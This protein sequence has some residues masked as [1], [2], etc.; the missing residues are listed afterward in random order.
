MAQLLLVAWWCTS[1]VCA[2]HRWQKCSDLSHTPNAQ[3]SQSSSSHYSLGTRCFFFSRAGA[4]YRYGFSERKLSLSFPE[5][6][7]KYTSGDLLASP[8]VSRRISSH[9][10]PTSET[11]RQR[12]R[13]A[14]GRRAPNR[15]RSASE[16]RPPSERPRPSSPTP[17]ASKRPRPRR[18]G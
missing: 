11:H 3:K 10:P 15:R 16:R 17:V 5:R 9:L 14:S 8:L 12:W 6:G 2:A 4:P 13:R 1:D 7:M 18:P